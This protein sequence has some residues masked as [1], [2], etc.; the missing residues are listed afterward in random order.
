M[1]PTAAPTRTTPM[2][3]TELADFSTLPLVALTE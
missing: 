1:A 2:A 3:R